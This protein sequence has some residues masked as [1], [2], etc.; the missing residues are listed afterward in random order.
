MDKNN[1]IYVEY[2]NIKRHYLSYIFYEKKKNQ[3]L[4][5][6]VRAKKLK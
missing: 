6:G 1:I 3:I 2:F 4:L 5:L